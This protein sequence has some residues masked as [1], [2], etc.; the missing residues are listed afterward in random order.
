MMNHQE[1]RILVS[2]AG[3]I[4]R[5]H[6]TNLSALGLKNLAFAD[7]HPDSAGAAQLKEKTGAL[8]FSD[9]GEALAAFKPSIVFICSPTILHVEQALA[10]AKAG[11]HLFIEKPLSHTLSGIEDLEREVKERNLIA[12]VACNMRFHPGPATFKKLLTERRI[13]DVLSARIHT[14]SFLPSWQPNH[15]YKARYSADPKQGGAILDCIHEIDL[16]LWFFG[17]AKLISAASVPATSIGLTVEGISEIILRHDA[18]AVSSIHLNFLQRNNRRACEV[19]G[20]E[21]TIEWDVHAE[22]VEVF[23]S[24]GKRSESIPLSMGWEDHAAY[25]LE[26]EHF[27]QAIGQGKAPVCSLADGRAA[28]EIALSAREASLQNVSP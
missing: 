25:E 15:N 18:G 14:G 1:H 16:A 22:K 13:G 12:M 21:G 11:C 9:F 10:A 3:S 28:L 17:R 27:L 8:P 2:G 26:I 4:G 6:L 19:I 23:G 24:D 7:P 5:R 20:T